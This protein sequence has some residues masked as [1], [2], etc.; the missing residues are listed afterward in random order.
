MG[1][2]N[3]SH[4]AAPSESLEQRPDRTSGDKSKEAVDANSPCLLISG[5]CKEPMDDQRQDKIVAETAAVQQNRQSGDGRAHPQDAIE[6]VMLSDSDDDN[7][8]V[9]AISDTECS[10]VVIIDKNEAVVSVE[11]SKG[12]MENIKVATGRYVRVL[13]ACFIEINCSIKWSSFVH[14]SHCDRLL[15]GSLLIT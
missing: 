3:D 7:N 5:T 15:S 12:S 9:I 10:D 13:L 4:R 14:G 8:S 6:L 2:K 11:D 1:S